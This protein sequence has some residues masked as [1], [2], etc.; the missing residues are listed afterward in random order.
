MKLIH[1]HKD[2]EVF[3]L[4]Y[5]NANKVF[6]M[7]KSFPREELYSLTDQIRRSSRSVATNIAEA[8]R[9]RRYE[10]A[11]ILK[12]SDSESEAAET[13]VWL[14][15]ALACNYIN[16]QLYDELYKT[17]DHILGMLVN[18]ILNSQKWSL[19]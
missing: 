7:T 13:Q 11:F 15:F 8:F 2:M 6:K 18:M 9:K 10:K 4:A 3:R 14:D 12:L 1:T 16:S 17:Y 5:D 19:K